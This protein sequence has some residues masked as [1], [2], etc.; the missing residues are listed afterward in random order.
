MIEFTTGDILG[1][2]AE[3]LVNTVNCVGIMGRGI[4]LQFKNRFPANFKAYAAACARE[5]V[6][7]GRMFV[8][9]THTLT[10][11]KFI[12]N[13]PT[14]RHWKGKS[15]M[16][17]IDSGLVALA[18]EIRARGIRS[19]AIPPLGSGLGG[20]NWADVRPRIEA[21]LRGINDLTVIVFE[22]KDAPVV[23]K[24]REVPDMTPGRAALVVL[25]HRYL[26]GLMDPFVT[27]LEIHKLMY[28]L[29]EAGEGLRLR[30]A[31]APYGPYAENLRH[32]LNAVEGHLVSGY[33]DGG[34]A[35]D[36]EIELV[37]G[38]VADAEAYLRD[39]QATVERFDR[40]GRLVEGFESPFGMELLATVHWV[41]KHEDA[42]TADEARA[43]VYAWN[44]RKKRFSPRQI[45]IAFDTLQAKGWLPAA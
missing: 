37:P 2:D 24:S 35:P 3:A 6:Q 32:V 7:P 22:P 33:A 20:L 12:V 13:F 17:D 10:N 14:K 25:M 11:P 8:F 39:K 36:K 43:K 41:V 21:A 26:A 42:T 27:L 18:E 1:A 5:E 40:V 45:G 29:Q 30:Y 15:R 31:K 28:F 23:T 9:E 16:E 19:I 38:A 34:D 4:A 44:E